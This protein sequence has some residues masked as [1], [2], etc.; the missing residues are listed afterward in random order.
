MFAR[1]DILINHKQ[2]KNLLLNT[3][4]VSKNRDYLRAVGN[5]GWLDFVITSAK[6]TLSN[7]P[8]ARQI[9][10]SNYNVD[11]GEYA[12]IFEL[13]LDYF[14]NEVMR[15]FVKKDIGVYDSNRSRVHIH[16][17]E[18]NVIRIGNHKSNY[19]FEELKPLTLFSLINN[20]NLNRNMSHAKIQW[21]LVTLGKALGFNVKVALDNKNL[22]NPVN[23]IITLKDVAKVTI[24]NLHLPGLLD[25]FHQKHPNLLATTKRRIDLI[26]VIWVDK[27]TN[28]VFSA[29]EIEGSRFENSAVKLKILSDSCNDHIYPILVIDDENINRV[30]T[31]TQPLDAIRY[32]QYLTVTDLI[33][34]L[35]RLDDKAFRTGC[36][37]LRNY[38][39]NYLVKSFYLN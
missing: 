16:F 1:S 34:A 5:K 20:T 31:A 23:N 18:Q 30:R 4:L 22:K 10:V 14:T 3:N 12:N 13:P 11:E 33:D 21:H 39:F 24:N 17:V 19:Y 6:K 36:L 27:Y 28:K 2:M 8:R 32:I 9:I 29:F 37:D 26:D 25:E 7:N 15:R 35:K 38:F